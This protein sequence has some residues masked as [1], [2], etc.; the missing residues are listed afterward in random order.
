MNAVTEAVCPEFTDKSLTVSAKVPEPLAFEKLNTCGVL[1]KSIKTPPFPE[2]LVDPTR[3]AV[4]SWVPP[5]VMP[6]G[7]RKREPQS[8]R[9]ASVIGQRTGK[10]K[11]SK[12]VEV[13]NAGRRW[14]SSQSPKSH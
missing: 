12:V 1:L 4:K 5:P 10:R 14:V 13:L 7:R 11:R 3:V 2:P 8:E 9:I 6:V